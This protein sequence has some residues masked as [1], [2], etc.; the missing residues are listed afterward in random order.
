MSSMPTSFEDAETTSAYAADGEALSTDLKGK[1]T[2]ALGRIQALEA[3]A[4]WGN[5]EPGRQFAGE[6]KEEGYVPSSQTY[7]TSAPKAGEAAVV[8]FQSVTSTVTALTGVDT[9]NKGKIDKAVPT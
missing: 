6:G 3:S 4:P 8:T 9:D 1:I 7:H 5:D 2:G